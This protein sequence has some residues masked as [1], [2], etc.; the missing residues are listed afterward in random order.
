MHGWLPAPDL[1][2]G[3]RSRDL[4]HTRQLVGICF[5]HQLIAQALGGRVELSTQGWGVG[6]HTYDVNPGFGFPGEPRQIAMQA[7]HQDQI[8]ELPPDA[9]VVASSAFCPIAMLQY[10]TQVRTV[11]AHPEFDAGFT[12]YLLELRRGQAI[13]EAVADL[14]EPTLDAPTDAHAVA[15]WLADCL[16]LGKPSV[17][18]WVTGVLG[19]EAPRV[20]TRDA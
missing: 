3:Q 9:E 4:C 20:Y 6:V 13:P 15:R 16:A 19:Y 2:R 11:Q 18:A 1:A 10:G 7:F 8:V 12:R 5:G 17:A 14:A